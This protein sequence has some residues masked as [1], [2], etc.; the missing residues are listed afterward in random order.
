MSGSRR[1]SSPG[2]LSQMTCRAPGARRSS[3][4]WPRLIFF[5]APWTGLAASRVQKRATRS[6]SQHFFVIC[7]YI[8]VEAQPRQYCQERLVFGVKSSSIRCKLRSCPNQRDPR[9]EQG[10]RPRSRA[11]EGSA[12]LRGTGRRYRM[13]ED[14]GFPRRIRGEQVRAGRNGSGRPLRRANDP[15]H[16]A[17]THEALDVA[18]YITD[19]TAQLE[20]MAIAAASTCSPISSGWPERKARFM[21][22]PT[23]SLKPSAWTSSSPSRLRLDCPT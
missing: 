22:A 19:M 4:R 9:V 13:I 20:A 12:S 17:V 2:R 6:L 16:R 8:I 21:F 14:M 5:R 11:P 1:L 7:L 18:R 3:T 15:S 23:P 10:N